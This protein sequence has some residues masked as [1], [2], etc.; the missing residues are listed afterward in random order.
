MACIRFE[1]QSGEN[2]INIE[3][4]GYEGVLGRSARGSL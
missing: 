3:A 4:D 2:S 1:F